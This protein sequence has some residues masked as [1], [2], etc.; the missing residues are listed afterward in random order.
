[1]QSIAGPILYTDIIASNIPSLFFNA[2]K[3]PAGFAASSARKRGLLGHCRSLVLESHKAFSDRGTS[4]RIEEEGKSL[5]K[6]LELAVASGGFDELFPRLERFSTSIYTTKERQNFVY[7]T[8]WQD[9]SADPLYAAWYAL[10]ETCSAPIR[11]SDIMRRYPLPGPAPDPLYAK[12]QPIE[13]MKPANMQ[14][15]PVDYVHLHFASRPLE[16]RYNVKTVYL[17]S[18]GTYLGLDPRMHLLTWLTNHAHDILRRTQQSPPDTRPGDK[19]DLYLDVEFRIPIVFVREF[20]TDIEALFA[21]NLQRI[22]DWYVKEGGQSKRVRDTWTIRVMDIVRCPACR[23]VKS[24]Y[25]AGME[26]RESF[27]KAMTYEHPK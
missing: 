10:M 1:L 16:I 4:A 7:G 5:T 13:R 23:T 14:P 26:D 8:L 22:R 27:V 25:E 21:G 19:R 6:A 9:H 17:V 2:V 18:V 24:R 11:C 12:P 3:G 15:D 20:V